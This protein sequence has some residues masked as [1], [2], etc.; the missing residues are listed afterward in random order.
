MTSGRVTIAEVARAAGVSKATVSLV[1]NGRSGA[2]AISA[3]T[4]ATV[5]DAAARLR[6]S[7]NRAARS[8]RSRRTNILTMLLSQLVSPYFADIAAAAQSAAAERDYELNIIDASSTTAK[9]RALDH[10]R[11]G[12]SD[13]VIIATGYRSTR[14]EALEAV[15]DLVRRG[16]PAVMVLDRSPDGAIPAI[17]IDNEAGIHAA[18]RH[19]IGLGHRRIAFLTLRGSHPPT[20]E[21]TSKADRYH[22]Y[23]RALAEAGLPFAPTWVYQ[24]PAQTLAGGRGLAHDLLASPAPRP[25]AAVA[26]N[27]PLALGALRAAHEAG[28]RVPDDLAL[29]GFGGIELGGYAVPA[30]ST[31]DHAREV[32][33][34]E[35]VATLLDLLGGRAPEAVDRVLPTTLL[36][37]ES[38]GAGRGA[39]PV[40]AR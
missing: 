7:P 19:L 12:G 26:F 28:A 9:L 13:G 16:M 4:Q 39:P 11:G 32:L 23:R 30:L 35:A 5:L 34:R 31:M 6:Y 1:L 15:Q 29:V 38:C 22:G 8:L 10:L 3:A 25:T 17:R 21:Q 2:V 14:D 37:R 33:G 20:E 27:D 36:V 18:T 40:P 24:A